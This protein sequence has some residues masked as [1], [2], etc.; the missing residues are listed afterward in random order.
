MTKPKPVQ[1]EETREEPFAITVLKARKAVE[2]ETSYFD[3]KLSEQR[4][5]NLD[6]AIEILETY[7]CWPWK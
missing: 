5:S 7:L 4:I 1:V 6:H 2:I 3:L